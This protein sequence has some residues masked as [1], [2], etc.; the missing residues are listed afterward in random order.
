MHPDL[1]GKYQSLGQLP[2]LGDQSLQGK[3]MSG[4]KADRIHA[5]SFYLR[6]KS[7]TL[8]QCQNTADEWLFRENK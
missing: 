8:G 4:I 2:D 1:L 3:S 5:V 6:K 7:G